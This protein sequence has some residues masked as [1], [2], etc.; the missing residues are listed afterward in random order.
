MVMPTP[1]QSASPSRAPAAAAAHKDTDSSNQSEFMSVR[2]IILSLNQTPN[3][4]N[5]QCKRISKDGR[6][7]AQES[8]LTANITATEM[9]EVIKLQMQDMRNDLKRGIETLANEMKAEFENLGQRVRDLEQLVTDQNSIIDRL[10]DQLNRKDEKIHSLLTRLDE[11]ERLQPPLVFS[12]VVVS[13]RPGTGEED[14]ENA[15][16]DLVNAP[17]A[18]TPASDIAKTFRVSGI[19][20]FHTTLLKS[21][22]KY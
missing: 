10:T 12:G 18:H 20:I 17:R 11:A 3:T 15:A 4:Q 1:K 7:K 22:K 8:S 6:T 19:D 16:T 2:D 5:R 21:N 9:R 13:V 14:F